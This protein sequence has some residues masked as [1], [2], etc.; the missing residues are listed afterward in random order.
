MNISSQID[1]CVSKMNIVL[2]YWVLITENV[3]FSYACICSQ[4]GRANFAVNMD[5]SK[6]D[7]IDLIGVFVKYYF[8]YRMLK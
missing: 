3:F 4:Q 5:L 7:T 8:V 6:L 2:I 1:K